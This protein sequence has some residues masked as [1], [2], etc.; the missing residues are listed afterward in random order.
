M[1][2]TKDPIGEKLR[3]TRESRGI[4]VPDLATA[5]GIPMA[6]IYKWEQG[7]SAPKFDDR[8]KVEDWINGNWKKIPNDSGKRSNDGGSD[9]YERLIEAIEARRQDAAIALEE[10]KRDKERLYGIIEKYLE[11]MN[12]N[13][14]TTKKVVEAGYKEMIAEHGVMMD[15]MDNLLKLPTGTTAAKSGI[16]ER[17]I[18]SNLKDVDMKGDTDKLRKQQ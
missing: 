18:G 11:G 9:A 15:G 3:S 16:V 1:E 8:Q 10:A 2:K 7:A 4:S 12:A 14:T 17:A 6:R 13:L 5:L